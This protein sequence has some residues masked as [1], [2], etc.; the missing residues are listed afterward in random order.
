MAHFN[1]DFHRP[2]LLWKYGKKIRMSS[3]YAQRVTHPVVAS[4]SSDSKG[5]GHLRSEGMVA[6][7][8]GKE[9][10]NASSKV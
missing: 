3:R 2:V 10:S 1:L 6:E 5:D 7:K 9:P 4:N 8:A